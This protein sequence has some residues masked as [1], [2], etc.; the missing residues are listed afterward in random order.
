MINRKALS[1]L[2]LC[3]RAGKLASG[4]L[5]CEKALQNSSALV[6]IIACDASENTKEKF[7]NKAFYYNVPVIEAGTRDELGRA[8]GKDFRAVLAVCDE[9]FADK[10]KECFELL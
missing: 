3:Q 8:I 5:S 4:E 7:K 1:M 2:S 9:N 6:I 10:I